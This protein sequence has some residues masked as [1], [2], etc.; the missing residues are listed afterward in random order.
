MGKKHTTLNGKPAYSLERM[1]LF[2]KFQSKWTED[3]SDLEIKIKVSDEFEYV[4]NK[5]NS[6]F[7]SYELIEFTQIRSTYYK[8]NIQALE[9]MANFG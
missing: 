5:L 8:N 9:T 7:T 2:S 3:L 6:E 4:L 1:N